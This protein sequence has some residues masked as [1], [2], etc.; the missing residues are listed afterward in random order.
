MGVGQYP[1]EVIELRVL[2]SLHSKGA[3]L[4]VCVCAWVFVFIEFKCNLYAV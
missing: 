2:Q 4:R 3:S 1:V